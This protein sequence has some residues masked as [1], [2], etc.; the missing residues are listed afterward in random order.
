V[1]VCVRVCVCVCVCACVRAR[2]RVCVCGWVSES[3]GRSRCCWVR[4][5]KEHATELSNAERERGAVAAG[6]IIIMNEAVRK[7]T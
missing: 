6:G 5:G 1:C 7:D 3:V 2:A 4:L